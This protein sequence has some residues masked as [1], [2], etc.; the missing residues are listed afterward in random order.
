MSAMRLFRHK[1]TGSIGEY[2]EHYASMFPNL[3]PV[4]EAEVCS[5]CMPRVVDR[6]IGDPIDDEDF[7]VDDRSFGDQT[8]YFEPVTMEER[9][10]TH[11]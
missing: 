4:D 9:W 3:E 6:S 10:D 11:E 2:P 5:D 7:Q 1:V 8:D